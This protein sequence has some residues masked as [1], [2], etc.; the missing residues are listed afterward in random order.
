MAKVRQLL[1]VGSELEKL[2]RGLFLFGHKAAAPREGEGR[3]ASEL[4]NTP[5]PELEKWMLLQ[6]IQ[7]S[8]DRKLFLGSQCC[9]RFPFTPVSRSSGAASILVIAHDHLAVELLLLLLEGVLH[10]FPL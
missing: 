3:G 10:L 1:L 9:N 7:E 6:V 8:R 5:T 4:G 2:G